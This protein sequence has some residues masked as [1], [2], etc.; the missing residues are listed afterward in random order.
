MNTLRFGSTGAEVE[1]L[2]LALQRAGFLNEAPDGVFGARTRD[3]VIRFQKANGLKTDG[4]VGVNTWGAL[5]KYLTGY[6]TH[7]VRSGDT[8]YKLA[9]R[10]NTTVRAIRTANPNADPM[11]LTIGSRLIIPYG[12][13]LVPTNISYSYLLL[14]YV[15]RGLNARYPFTRLSSVGRT[16]MGKE[17]YLLT[18]GSG[19]KQVFYNGAFHANEWITTPV[20]LKFFEEYAYQYSVG[21][22]IGNARA[23]DIYREA[24]I[25]FVPMVNPD[26]VDLVTGALTSGPF[27][28]RAKGY[29][30]NYPSVPFPSGWKANIAGVDLNLQYPALWENAR[31][32]F[33]KQG[34]VS[35]APAD[36]VGTAPLTQPEAVNV[37]NYTLEN[38]FS[39]ILAYHTQGSI[40]YWKFS[41][42]EPPRSKE[43]GEILSEVSGY[44]LSLTP[45]DQSFAGYKDWFIQTY[46]LPG[47]TVEAGRGVNPLPVSQFD[48]IYAAN[49]GILVS[50]ALEA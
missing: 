45:P 28:N 38:D 5:E 40:I 2:Q 7:T 20:L 43:I 49:V 44:P 48:E 50:A 29:A 14:R 25:S 23:S 13:D 1:A 22:A 19:N 15:V 37:Y 46:N 35:P 4:V 47:Y 26:G 27:Y 33:A 41:D 12:F 32:Y 8:Y 39:L 17:Q 42:Y 6:T 34:I 3:A 18:I 16:V 9:N 30:D 24:T 21:G 31:D 11:N 36:F 10:Y